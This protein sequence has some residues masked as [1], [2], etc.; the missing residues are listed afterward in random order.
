M[1]SN[2]KHLHSVYLKLKQCNFCPTCS[3][4]AQNMPQNQN[5]MNRKH[6]MRTILI[7]FMIGDQNKETCTLFSVT[8]SKGGNKASSYNSSN[9][10]KHRL[11]VVAGSVTASQP[12]GP[13]FETELRFLCGVFV[14]IL[15][16][17][18]LGI[19]HLNLH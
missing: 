12:Q 9:L 6:K 8:L 17:R 11:K 1:H 3:I 18:I 2:R 15:P 13:K 4:I 14:H 5:P 10:M 19:H 16:L 7:Y